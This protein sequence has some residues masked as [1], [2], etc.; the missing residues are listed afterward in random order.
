MSTDRPY[1]LAPGFEAA[2]EEIQRNKGVKYHNKV[3][4]AFLKVIQTGFTF[5][6]D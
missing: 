3:V 6:V 2:V 5:D 1:R 4:D